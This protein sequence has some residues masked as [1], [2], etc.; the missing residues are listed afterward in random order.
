MASTTIKKYKKGGTNMATPILTPLSSSP[1]SSHSS[2]TS[3]EES[4]NH[5]A[6]ASEPGLATKTLGLRELSSLRKERKRVN[7]NRDG[8]TSRKEAGGGREIQIIRNVPDIHTK[9]D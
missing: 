5:L 6:A 8:R 3:E 7:S 9:D 1:E 2:L 4:F